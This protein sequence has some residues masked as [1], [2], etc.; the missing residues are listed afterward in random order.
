MTLWLIKK[1]PILI[2]ILLLLGLCLIG[3]V[4]VI[5]TNISN[6]FGITEEVTDPDPVVGEPG[7]PIVVEPPINTS[8]YCTRVGDAGVGNP[9][10]GYPTNANGVQS[11]GYIGTDFCDPLYPFS[12]GHEGLD[13]LYWTGIPVIATANGTIQQAGFDTNLGNVVILCSGSWCAR[14]GHMNSLNVSTG[15]TVTQG[16]QIGVVGNT[17]AYTT[18]PH[19]HYDMY[20]ADGFWDPF[21]TLN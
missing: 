16:E 4:T 10:S 9:F 13:F 18:G 19:L 1:L 2:P 17:G 8:E 11:P 5:A 20:N 12:W 15:Q 3:I 6:G 21:P 14:F 7:G